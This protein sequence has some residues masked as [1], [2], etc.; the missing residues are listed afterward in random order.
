MLFF[1]EA[2]DKAPNFAY[3]PKIGVFLFG[4]SAVFPSWPAILWC[5]KRSGCQGKRADA[6]NHA[7]P[8]LCGE[9]GEHG[10]HWTLTVARTAL[11]LAQ[12]RRL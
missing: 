12:V 7:Q 3:H 8:L 10:E 11:P 2:P 1:V 4:Q 9:H 5:A 6:Q